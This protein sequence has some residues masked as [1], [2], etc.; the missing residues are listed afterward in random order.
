MIRLGKKNYVSYFERHY[1]T[2]TSIRYVNRKVLIL[3]KKEGFIQ[4]M[5]RLLFN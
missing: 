4:D 1:Y 2:T 3:L 5:Y